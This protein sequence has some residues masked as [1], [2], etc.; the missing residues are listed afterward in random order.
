LRL[1]VVLALVF[2]KVR[3]EHENERGDE[4]D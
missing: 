1:C 4:D 3:I 2:E